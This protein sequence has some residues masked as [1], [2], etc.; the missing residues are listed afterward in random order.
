[1]FACLQLFVAYFKIIYH[2]VMKMAMQTCM[3]V[4]KH[5]SDEGDLAD[6]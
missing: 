3:L 4:Y 6:V 5:K 1:M 2:E